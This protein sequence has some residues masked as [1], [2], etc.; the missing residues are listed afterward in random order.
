MVINQYHRLHRYRII[1]L[2]SHRNKNRN[3]QSTILIQMKEQILKTPTAARVTIHPTICKTMYSIQAKT[4]KKKR[5]V[6][7]IRL[8]SESW[9]LTRIIVG[10]RRHSK[11]RAPSRTEIATPSPSLPRVKRIAINF[12]TCLSRWVRPRNRSTGSQR[13]I[14]QATFKAYT[15]NTHKRA[16]SWTLTKVWTQVSIIQR[17]RVFNQ[18]M[19]QWQTTLW[20]SKL[21]QSPRRS[22]TNQLA[23]RPPS[24]AIC[25][26]HQLGSRQP[27]LKHQANPNT[28]QTSSPSGLASSLTAQASSHSTLLILWISTT[29]STHRA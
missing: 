14:L 18:G 3:H 29:R 23:K 5:R 10:R 12:R 24:L 13:A 26:R 4:W 20:I 19:S 17:T 25:T 8:L 22:L 11:T 1:S 21:S 27:T 15:V 28:H 2:R 7:S 9:I 16:V 6:N